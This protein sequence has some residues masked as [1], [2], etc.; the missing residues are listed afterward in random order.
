MPLDIDFGQV[1]FF[2]TDGGSTMSSIWK[3]QAVDV[4]RWENGNVFLTYEEAQKEKLR[5]IVR[6]CMLRYGRKEYKPDAD[7]VVILVNAREPFSVCTEDH[8]EMR[9]PDDIYFD[10]VELAEMAISDIG[11]DTFRRLLDQPERRN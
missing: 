9:T 8:V 2:L 7:N 5:H 4:L 11:E 1:Y 6:T 3:N 10:S